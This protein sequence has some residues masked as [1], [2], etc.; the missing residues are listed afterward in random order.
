[1]VTKNHWFHHDNVPNEAIYLQLVVLGHAK[2]FIMSRR[3]K[4][5]MP[6]ST[7]Q[8]VPFSI[9][10]H[11]VGTPQL[12]VRDGAV[13]TP[14][15]WNKQIPMLS[16]DWKCYFWPTQ[17]NLEVFHLILY[18][19]FIY[20]LL[21]LYFSRDA[22]GVAISSVKAKLCA[23]QLRTG[24]GDSENYNYYHHYILNRMIYDRAGKLTVIL[25]SNISLPVSNLRVL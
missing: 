10:R 9:N 5:Y 7:L 15:L 2:D 14:L 24:T 25:S 11:L 19:C 22:N 17:Q 21:I 12:C 23:P 16:S 3:Y 6:I 4:K 8:P 13:A 20:P 18:H 1:M